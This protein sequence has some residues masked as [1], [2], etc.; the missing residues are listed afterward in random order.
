VTYK[1][2]NSIN[3]EEAILRKWSA[4][5]LEDNTGRILIDPRKIDYGELTFT[6]F[7]MA[8]PQALYLIHNWE[9]TKY[10]DGPEFF[11]ST[12]TESM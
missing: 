10:K 3:T 4:F 7:S 1:Q 8:D 2:G 5:Y 11:L 12:V 6:P 9:A